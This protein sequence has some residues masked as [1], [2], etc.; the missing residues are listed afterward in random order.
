MQR[1]DLSGKWVL[2]SAKGDRKVPALVPGDTHSALLAAGVISDPY[3]GTN[4]K[5]AQWVGLENWVYCRT[6]QVTPAFLAHTSIFLNCDCL[7]TL[8]T[9][10]INGRKAGAS[11][12]MFVR[13][14]FEV[15]SLL[16]T[17]ANEIRIVFRSAERAAMAA[18]KKQP[19]EIFGGN[20]HSNLI[21]KVQCHSGWDWGCRLM[22]AGIHGP[23]GLAATDLGRIE[24]VGTTQRHRG[25]TVNVD[26]TVEVL[27]PRGGDTNLEIMLGGQ[28]VRKPV[29]LAAGLNVV[30]ARVTIRN[31]QLWWPA[32]MGKQP[33]YDLTVRI[34]DDTLS[35]RLGLRT[36]KL[37]SKPD[38]IGRSMFFRV[39]GR[40]IFCKGANW[41][42]VDALPQRHTRAVYMDLIAS[43][44]AANMN[45]LRVW[46]GGQYEPDMFYDLCDEQGILVWQD[47]MFAC[48][49]YPSDPVFLESVR[50]EI[51]H[52]VK[53]LCNHACL[54]AWCGSNEDIGALSW[55][56]K[57]GPVRDRAVVDY[58][59]LTEGVIGDTIRKLDPHRGFWPSS[60][61]AGPNNFANCWEDDFHGDMHCWVDLQKETG[62]DVY[63]NFR[64]RFSSEFGV[65]AFPS[66]DLI[67][68][69][70]PPA[71]HNATSPVMEFHQ[72]HGAGNA[73]ITGIFPRHFRE[74]EGFENTVY[75]SQVQQALGIKIAVEAWRRLRPRCMG[76]LYWQFNDNWPVAS[77]SS[78][79]YGGKWKLLH[80]AARRFYAPTAVTVF[81]KEGQAEVWLLNDTPER[82]PARVTIELRTFT[83]KVLRREVVRTHLPVAGAAKIRQYEVAKLAPE[84]A[85]AFLVVT[86]KAG[87]TGFR[88][89]HFFCAYKQCELPR[90]RVR[91]VAG[92]DRS[93]RLT[94]TLSTDKPAFFVAVNADRLRGEFDDNC[95]TLLPGEPQTLVFAAKQPVTLPQFRRALSVKHLRDTYT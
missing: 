14:R 51:T 75:L 12:N 18:A 10:F 17:G 5:D 63:K 28:D 90:A 84:P 19:Y 78:V 95:F 2:Q 67:R 57:P 40:D 69:F 21:R 30:T 6:F 22:V 48:A 44:A 35:R 50:R 13:N 11:D 73:I 7:D 3:L 81:Q 41:I 20:H 58:D 85:A 16:E 54:I 34:A 70:A 1:I 93:G 80:Y 4:E 66:M 37:V 53:R 88:N 8:A 72:R 26:V 38:K 9:V 42:P 55:F 47:A 68:T 61:C 45:M 31:P 29:T 46:G 49:L 82:T 23:I 94:A 89:E 91:C 79:E 77:W 59:R 15:K 27:S 71:Q 87:A 64:P 36:V 60:P 76:T 83:G 92:Q 32:G 25:Q 33:L 39:N 56:T 62:L 52:Q 24:Y 86:L 74:P 65:Q 43:A